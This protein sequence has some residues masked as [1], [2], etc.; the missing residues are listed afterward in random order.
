MN[1]ILGESSLD[2]KELSP[3]MQVSPDVF[4]KSTAK[5]EPKPEDALIPAKYLEAISNCGKW[6][7]EVDDKLREVYD[8]EE[9]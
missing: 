6:I 1:D 9:V 8:Y 2:R 4:A 3:E 5:K 7:L